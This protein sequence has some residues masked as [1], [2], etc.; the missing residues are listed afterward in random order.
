VPD[1][2]Q[3]ACIAQGVVEEVDIGLNLKQGF[4]QSL[5]RTFFTKQCTQA[6]VTSQP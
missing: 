3:T 6:V 2:Q 5:A 1:L 4:N